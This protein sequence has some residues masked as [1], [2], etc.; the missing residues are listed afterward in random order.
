MKRIR[1]VLITLSVLS[2]AGCG[3]QNTPEFQPSLQDQ[4]S[5]YCLDHEGN[6][7]MREEGGKL[8]G[9]CI[10]A[11]GSQCAEADFFNGVCKAGEIFG[12][13][14]KRGESGALS[15]D[16]AAEVEVNSGSAEADSGADEIVLE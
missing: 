1:F 4:I 9:Y 11:D 15:A 12:E 5:L 6:L 13:A 14:S 2:F 16:E 7:E 3:L 10:F 8:H